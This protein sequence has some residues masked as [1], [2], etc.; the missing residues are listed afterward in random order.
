MIVLKQKKKEYYI[1]EYKGALVC[2]ENTW[3][4]WLYQ[5]A[6]VNIELRS[7]QILETFRKIL[8]ED[9]VILQAFGTPRKVIIV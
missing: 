4:I 3:L 7:Q 2:I 1:A 9:S 5:I 8:W 6:S